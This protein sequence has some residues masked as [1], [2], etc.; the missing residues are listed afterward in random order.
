MKTEEKKI[1]SNYEKEKTGNVLKDKGK[2]YQ[3]IG[4]SIAVLGG[5]SLLAKD[6]IGFAI[7]SGIIFAGSI[8][9]VMGFDVSREG[10][11]ILK[12]IKDKS[13]ENIK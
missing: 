2:V 8:I 9:S 10:S 4:L 7:S 12:E 5:V 3:T 6:L 11:K 1:I 13:E